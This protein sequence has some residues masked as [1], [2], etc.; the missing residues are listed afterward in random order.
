MVM[1]LGAMVM[2]V[3]AEEAYDETVSVTGLQEGDVAHFYKV[4]EWVG[5]AEGN[6]KGW[7]AVSPFVFTPDLGTV[8]EGKAAVAADPENGIEAQDAIPAGISATL[9]NALADAATGDGFEVP[10]TGT[11]AELNVVGTGK[12]AGIYMVLIEPADPNVAYNPVFVSSDYD[13][14]TDPNTNTWAISEVAS[15]I[16]DDAAAKKSTT[17]LDK[18]ASTEESAPDD[19]KWITTAIGDTVHFTITTTIPGFGNAFINPMFKLTDSLTDLEL[20]AGTVEIKSPAAAAASGAATITEASDRKS[21]TVNFATNYLKTVTAPTEVTIEYDAI[22]TSTA[23]LNVNAEKNEVWTEFSHNITDEN[24]HSFKKDTTQH[25]TFTIGA[26]AIAGG[27]EAEGKKG[28][29]IV[30][31]SRDSNGDP[32]LERTETSTITAT[33]SWESPQADAHF[34]LYR[35]EACTKEYIPKTTTGAEGTALDIT[36]GEDGR[37]TIAGLDAG[38]YW[39]KEVSCPAG[40]VMDTHVAHIVISTT[41]SSK[42]VT[43]YTTDGVTW[44]SAAEYNE[45]EAEQKANYKSYTYATNTLDSYT[46][47]IDGEVAADYKFVNQGSDAVIKWTET[48]PVELPHQFV[49]N[50]GVQLPSTGGVGTT[51]FYVIGA[52]LVL[53]AGILLVTRRRMNAN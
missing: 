24:D 42:N 45:L 9:A 13:K 33:N 44:I 40:Y 25:Y 28:S 38:E 43:E 16:T 7:K 3:M 1:V 23:P 30:K 48:P 20:V 39:L 14:T 27:E 50:E 5:S 53:G 19:V 6:Y 49:N 52:I 11:A 34:K 26:E 41:E 29:E 51:I 22:V 21:Y 47:T 37:M 17:T 32:V 2:P 15:Y 35:D 18:T 12:G 8:L 31:V 4:V 10:V 46:I 36:S